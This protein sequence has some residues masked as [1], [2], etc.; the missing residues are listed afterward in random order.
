[1]RAYTE[2]ERSQLLLCAHLGAEKAITGSTFRRLEA[3]LSVLGPGKG[4][5]AGALTE[6]D[7]TRLG[8]SRA[9]AAAILSRLERKEALELHLEQLW[10][11][12][13]TPLVRISPEY[14]QRLRTVLRQQ[15]PLL[16]YCAG[17]LGLFQTECVSLVG[18]RQLR[19]PGRQFSEA[20]G[21][22]A[23][24]EGL[25]YVSGGAAGADSVGL[26]AA[27]EAGGQAIVFVADSL[28]RRM[29]QLKKWLETGRLLL[30]SE[31]GFDQPFSAQRAYSRNRLIHAMGRKVFVAQAEY[32]SGGTWNGVMENV[33]N[34]WSPVWMCNEEPEDAGTRGLLR[35]GCEPVTTAELK[36]LRA[37]GRVQTS[38]YG[39]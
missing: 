23:A 35:Q 5:P 12:N 37:L 36:Q 3:A 15:A 21:R 14:P 7:L 38:L 11:R 2:T 27:M 8:L 20:L 10:R 19:R 31:H 33:R 32:G 34:D 24:G 30:V 6:D 1:M 26:E 29:T 25:T 18:A 28:T 4:D 17:A 13:I 39:P 22:S 16:L 9:D